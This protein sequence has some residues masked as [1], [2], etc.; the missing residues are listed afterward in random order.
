MPIVIYYI[1]YLHMYW[2]YMNIA[3]VFM[4]TWHDTRQPLG[5]FCYY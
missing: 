5:Y 3:A 1:H 4:K 2:E